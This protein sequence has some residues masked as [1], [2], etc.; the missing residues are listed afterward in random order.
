MDKETAALVKDVREI[1]GLMKGLRGGS[2]YRKV[3]EAAATIERLSRQV[4]AYDNLC[5]DMIMS[6]MTVGNI[7][8]TDTGESIAVHE[9]YRRDRER[10]WEIK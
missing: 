9:Y 2:H 6:L 10:I 1:A 8:V 3:F 5:D 4:E 7:L